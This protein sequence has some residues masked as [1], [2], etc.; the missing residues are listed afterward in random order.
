MN[1]PP[2]TMATQHPDNASVPWWS[3][4]AF[5]NTQDEI[6]ELLTLFKELP[7]DE[8][9]WDW[10]GKFVDE[11]VGEKLYSRDFEYFRDH[12]LGRDLFLT[13]RIP[14]WEEGKVY[15]MARAFMNVLSMADM[16]REIQLPQP[17]VTEMF[18]PM[19]TSSDQLIAVL[20]AFRETADH[21]RAIFHNTVEQESQ[22]LSLVRVTPLVEDVDSLFTI[23]RILTPYWSWLASGKGLAVEAGQRV[24]LARSDPAMNS[25]L[26][27]AMLAVK[28]A[29]S[30]VHAL[31]ERMGFG[32]HPIIGTGSLPFR[33]G[34]NPRSLD[35]FLPQYAGTRTY[36]IQSAYRYDYPKEEVLASLQRL[37]REVPQHHVVHLSDAE[38]VE[39][40]AIAGSFATFW[41]PTIEALAP[42]INQVAACIPQRRE[43][44]QHIGLFGYSRGVGQ[45]KLPR[46]IGFTAAFYSLGLPPELIAT[47]RGLRK[48]KTDGTLEAVLRHY[49]AL[50]HDMQEA[51]H[52]LHRESL[53][54]LRESHAAIAD[55]AEDIDAI[56]EVLQIRLGPVAPEH[57]Q[58]AEVVASFL[59]KLLRSQFSPDQGKQDVEAMGV[60]RRSLG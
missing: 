23:E 27:P 38:R 22:I 33:G 42:L 12:V 17:P 1:W 14:A 37:H 10:E 3:D 49:P 52:Y 31:G 32:V 44:M 51:G 2:I 47:G 6:V 36:S 59:Q 5:V 58:H 9:M 48:A 40:H 57:L 16:A 19:T 30:S 25:G 55:I 24:F 35:S 18:V 43:R 46:A 13:Y 8:Y 60:L 26:V 54:L 4:R 15:R 28:A 7:I 11:S 41:K 21:H 39:L 56:E 34:V 20:S 50:A 53:S 45:V 29:L